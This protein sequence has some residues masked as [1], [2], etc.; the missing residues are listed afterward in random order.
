LKGNR[1]KIKLKYSKKEEN[2]ES[3]DGVVRADKDWRK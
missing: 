3:E 1:N 2:W